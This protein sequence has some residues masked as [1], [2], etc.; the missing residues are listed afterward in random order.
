MGLLALPTDFLLVVVYLVLAVLLLRQ[1]IFALKEKF[2]N[3]QRILIISL[4]D[5][6]LT[7]IF[8][9]LEDL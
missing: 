1:L 2:S 3:R 5:V 8:S 4:L 9:F 7:L 6:V